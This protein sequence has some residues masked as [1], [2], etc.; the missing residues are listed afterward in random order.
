M[1]LLLAPLFAGVVLVQAREVAIVPLVEGDVAGDGKPGLAEFF[2][3]EI[4]GALGAGEFAGEG[5]VEAE[6]LGLQLAAGG[7]RL[8]DA[9]LGQIRVLPAGEEVLQ[10]PFALAVADE[11]ENAGHRGCLSMESSDA[12]VA[13]ADRNVPRPQ[14]VRP[15]TSRME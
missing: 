15:R 9:F 4:E 11:D 2:E 12:F 7:F 8:L 5:G 3:H 1:H 13:R 14:P 6:A 10:V